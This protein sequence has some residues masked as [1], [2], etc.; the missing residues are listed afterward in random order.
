MEASV[1]DDREEWIFCHYKYIRSIDAHETPQIN[2]IFTTWNSCYRCVL[3]VICLYIRLMHTGVYL[4]QH[5]KSHFHSHCI[6]SAIK[7]TWYSIYQYNSCGNWAW[8]SLFRYFSSRW[9]QSPAT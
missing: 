6:N 8:D 1:L 9:Q 3:M 5:L 7:I 2:S 4:R